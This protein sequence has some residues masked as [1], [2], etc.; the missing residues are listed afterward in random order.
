MDIF[1]FAGMESTKA[2]TVNSHLNLLKRILNDK[3]FM[4]VKNYIKKT[5]P[6]YEFYIQKN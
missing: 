5:E 4:N 3:S 6:F 2:K 1:P